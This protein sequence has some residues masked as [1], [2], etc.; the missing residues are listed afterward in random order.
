MMISILLR[1]L[2]KN[3]I[4]FCCLFSIGACQ[5]TSMSLDEARKVGVD[6]E[7]AMLVLPPRG[8]G[9]I[10]AELDRSDIKASSQ[11][12]AIQV[13]ADAKVPTG[14]DGGALVEFY[15]NRAEHAQRLGRVRQSLGDFGKAIDVANQDENYPAFRKAAHQ[16]QYGL[17]LVRTGNFSEGLIR[18][19]ESVEE[20]RKIKTGQNPFV[21]G[22]R[23]ARLSVFE[24]ILGFYT[25]EVGDFDTAKDAFVRANDLMEK[26]E[27]L[28]NLANRENVPLDSET[29]SG[30]AITKS[31]NFAARARAEEMQGNYEEA[32]KLFRV[33]LRTLDD[34]K[35]EVEGFSFAQLKS[36]EISLRSW[37]AEVLLKLSQMSAS[38]VEARQA[39]RLVIETKG[40]LDSRTSG[41]L[42]TLTELMLVMAR[43][44]DAEQLAKRNLA[45]LTQIHADQNSLF[46]ITAK[47][48]L[49]AALAGQGEW[50]GAANLFNL[51]DLANSQIS[52][53]LRT[54]LISDPVRSLVLLKAGQSGEASIAAKYYADWI[55]GIRGAKS[56]EFAEADAFHAATLVNAN[57]KDQALTVLRRT[58][59]LLVTSE[60]STNYRTQLSVERLKVIIDSYIG[61]LG[62]G[63]QTQYDLQSLFQLAE[64]VRNDGVGKTIAAAAARTSVRVP[65]L[66][67]LV[68][69]EQ[70]LRQ[71][72]EAVF[73]ILSK[74]RTDNSSTEENRV[75]LTDRAEKLSRAQAVLIDEI[76]NQYPDYDLL[77]K[78][79]PPTFAS[80]R[81]RLDEN[82]TLISIL[83]GDK[84][85]HIWVIRK[86]GDIVFYSANIGKSELSR[87]V[88][89]LR[90]ALDP[91][92]IA[93][94][95][96]IP[97]FDISVAHQLYLKLLE[98]VREGWESSKHIRLVVDAPLG[99]LP[100]SLLPT[101]AQISDSDNVLFDRYQEV[102][103]L[104]KTHAISMLPTAA[105]LGA[106]DQAPTERSNRRTYIGFGD[107]YFSIEQQQLAHKQITSSEL[108]ARSVSLRSIPNTREINNA[109]I[110]RL[111]RL[112]DTR[113]EI[114][115]IANV[116][117]A[118]PERDIY[119][120]ER[121][122]EDVVKSKDLLPYDI[123]SFATHGL[124]SG[125]LDGL[126][127]PALALSSPEVTGGNDDGLLTMDEI[128][129]LK[130]D[131]EWAV[132]SACNTAAADGRGVEAVSG[133]GRAFFYAGARALL[134]SNW[135]VHSAATTELMKT[136]FVIQS[137]NAQLD[138]AEMLRQ[139]REYLIENAV[140]K[141]A[142]GKIAFSYAHP[143][144]WA[145]FTI[146]GDGSGAM[147]Q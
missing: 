101:S 52:T 120:G 82:D 99:T 76:R 132:L 106:F 116:L 65:G 38:E 89:T 27:D 90:A 119:L 59:P 43:Y 128:L 44:A 11:V 30:V 112:P 93:T 5:S 61:L 142:D 8:I 130:L 10:L 98:P 32:E 68:R 138:R 25:S 107:P 139:T 47:Q 79:T 77:L 56:P 81:Q 58:V 92:R 121:A 37:L 110:N 18:L 24:S 62:T 129:G 31:M 127:Q 63:D 95:G 83:S 74:L 26:V 21:M 111:P 49:A 41:V 36:T 34:V 144:F 102:S 133:L 73:S 131:A 96:D 109:Q 105:A 17:N 14:L 12:A 20:L 147:H 146:V 115:A 3:S 50:H 33:S 122:N 123:I 84:K 35:R 85:T 1:N 70:D 86:K 29:L 60:L 124:V 134:V 140:F 23:F 66:G 88:N 87:H 13:I 40:V 75:L 69:Q 72:S 80:L 16:A 117:S 114:I 137:K 22:H 78:P 135:P 67:K 6:L 57:E 39:L 100:F 4:V 51:I 141:S 54:A 71:K 55:R 104:S 28:I 143:I 19:R 108:I 7:G 53:S 91:G 97:D 145:P 9:D 45:M 118:D 2:I 94:L 136:L 15:N 48:Q 113:E 125:D 103:W 42:S 126:N 64:K 46:A